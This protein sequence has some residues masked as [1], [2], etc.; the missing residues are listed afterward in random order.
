ME[1]KILDVLYILDKLPLLLGGLKI[2][3][4]VSIVCI[5]M[6]LVIGLVGGVIRAL[7]I[8][9]LS[10]ILQVIIEFIR[11]TP[12][13]VHL[14]F[15][16][17]GLPS[18]GITISPVITGCIALSL[19]G[20]VYAIENF[21]GGIAAVQK[22]LIEASYSLGL[23]WWQTLRH[24]I[25][26]LGFRISF[27]AFSNTAISVLKNSSFLTGIG[28][29]ELTYVAMDRVSTDFKT[30]EMFISIAI[31][32]LLLVWITTMIFGII[33]RRLDYDRHYQSE[34]GMNRFANT[35]RQFTV[36]ARRSN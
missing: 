16:Y 15:I 33:E 3:L 13:L 19:W 28:V 18:I 4:W 1:V 11:N 26:P 35:F 2:T 29:A 22:P 12:L 34:K 27:P 36:L 9:V 17:F 5:F 6:S 10:Q 30:Y 14:F 7:K 24:I 31:I 23:T 21:R 25:V 8:P 32:Y 20:G